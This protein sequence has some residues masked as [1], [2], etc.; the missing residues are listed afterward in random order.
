MIDY[1]QIENFKSLRKVS[2]PLGRLSLFFGMNGMGKSS[3]LQALLLLRQSYWWGGDRNLERLRINASLVKLGSPSDIL[4][5]NADK[6][7]IRFYIRSDDGSV[8]DA[9]FV[10]N[11]EP[12]RPT[13]MHR[14]QGA[15]D[16]WDDAYDQALFGLN[17]L[18]YLGANHVGPQTTYD[19]SGWDGEAS[20]SL[21]PD[22]RYVVP[23]LASNGSSFEVAPELRHPRT[24]S[25]YL[26]DQVSAWMSEI[27]PGVRLS[28]T[29][30]PSLLS[31]EL[32]VRYD[33]DLLTTSD[34]S[35]VNVGFG[36][37]HVLPIIVELLIAQP[38]D[39]VALENPESHLHPR[40]QVAIARLIAKT[41]ARGVQVICESH[42]D[43]VINGV[44]LAVK[45]GV[46]D[47]GELLVSYFDKDEYQDTRIH[48]IEVDSKGALSSYPDGLLDEW[49]VLMAQL[50]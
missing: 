19:Y 2:L 11:E 33:A 24:Q 7:E 20:D 5:Q 48:H 38:G 14:R 44:R 32:R 47:A 13:V 27:S 29:A 36:I 41:A 28:A 35:P 9:R 17:S 34:I 1:L 16:T 22:G 30:I 31:A 15:I 4:C 21:G 25:A 42:S 18:Y 3:V 10:A 23:F 49:G 39:L 37:P 43:H 6:E 12:G 45:Q 26:I 46:L 40:G 50:I 8:L